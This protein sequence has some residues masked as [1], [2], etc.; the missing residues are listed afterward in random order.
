MAERVI[1]AIATKEDEEAKRALPERVRREVRA[2]KARGICTETNPFRAGRLSE[3]CSESPPASEYSSRANS[4]LFGIF[5][6]VP[7][8]T[9]LSAGG[10]RSR[11]SEI[12]PEFHRILMGD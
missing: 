4:N 8:Q 10:V 1:R 7:F 3:F 9:L 2:G 5:R 6:L 12:L 11:I